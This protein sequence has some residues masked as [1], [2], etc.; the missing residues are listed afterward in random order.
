MNDKVSI[1]IPVYNCKQYISRCVLSLLKQTYENIELVLID[2]GSTDGSGDILDSYSNDL[3]V[4]VYHIKNGGVSRARNYGI[5]HATGTWIMF[6]DADDFVSCNYVDTLLKAAHY[7]KVQIA[8]CSA[9]HTFDSNI[10]SLPVL[11]KSRVNYI[12][13]DEYDFTKPYEHSCC[14]GAIY[15]RDVIEDISFVEDLYVGEDTFFFCECLNK[16]DYVVD[17]GEKLYCYIHYENSLMHGEWNE[18]KATEL[19]AW[20]RVCKLFSK[21]EGTRIK[22]SSEL[23]VPI[24]AFKLSNRI[25]KIKNGGNYSDFEVSQ[26]S[27]MRDLMKTEISRIVKYKPYNR[28]YV[29]DYIVYCLNPRLFFVKTNTIDAVKKLLKRGKALLVS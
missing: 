26:I 23:M 12:K 2:D 3:R 18:K 4:S 29:V 15:H 24:M 16:C 11:E 20:K 28:G 19:L 10:Q 25:W 9:Y 13:V 27:D 17:V 1:I 14:W 22:K 6:V 5:K 7:Y 21:R 8:T